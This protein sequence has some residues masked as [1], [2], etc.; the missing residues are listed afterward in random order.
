MSYLAPFPRYSRRQ[1]QNRYIWL[2]LLCLTPPAE[3]FPWDDLREI[4]SGCQRMAKVPNAVEI[5]P[6][7]STA[8][9][10]RT[11][12][13]DRQT[14]DRQTDRRPLKNRTVFWDRLGLL[15]KQFVFSYSAGN[16]DHKN[17]DGLHQLPI[18][19]SN[20]NFIYVNVTLGGKWG[21]SHWPNADDPTDL[22]TTHQQHRLQWPGAQA[23][24]RLNWPIYT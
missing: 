15:V 7:I 16:V 10:G 18:H 14:D 20:F 8:W 12:V 17:R 4:F 24:L 3:G 9:V 21:H 13:T 22:V 19:Q 6:K 2:H 1:V 23:K 11:S 5:K